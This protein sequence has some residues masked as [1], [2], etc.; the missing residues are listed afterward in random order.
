MVLD[1]FLEESANADV[2]SDVEESQNLI[3]H[4]I[5]PPK[6]ATSHAT[7]LY[8]HNLK[9][10]TSLGPLGTFVIQVGLDRQES[11]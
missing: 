9:F 1:V 2:N 11:S 3:F 10:E 4:P 8:N 7:V 5:I 6:S